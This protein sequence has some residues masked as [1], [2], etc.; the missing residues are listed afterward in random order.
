MSISYKGKLALKDIIESGV[1]DRDKSY[2]ID[3]NYWKG[4]NVEQ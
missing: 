2:C 1:V 3:A 4:T